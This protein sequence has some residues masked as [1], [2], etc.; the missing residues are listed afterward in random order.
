MDLYE[1]ITTLQDPGLAQA[2]EDFVAQY[3]PEFKQVLE[4]HPLQAPGGGCISI[5]EAFWSYYLVQA[6]QPKVIIESGS[7]EGFSLYFLLRAAPQAEAHAFDPYYS[8]KAVGEFQYHD[9]DWIEYTFDNLPGQHTF[10]FFDDHI[11]AGMRMQQAK[12]RGVRHLLFHDNYLKAEHCLQS[13]MTLRYWGVKDLA[14]FQYI[15]PRLR[16]DPI[17]TS[18]QNNPQNYRWLTYVELG[19]QPG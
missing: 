10:V 1:I 4:A 17:F 7:L 14:S 5:A 2:L 8:P 19:E 12:E 3:L 16:C 6:L 18:T 11:H 15:F 9:C 13:H